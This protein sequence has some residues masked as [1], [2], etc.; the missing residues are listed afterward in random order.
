MQAPGGKRQ[1]EENNP[2]SAHKGPYKTISSGRGMQG[3]A[4]AQKLTENSFGS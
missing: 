4:G 3:G 1:P 2:L